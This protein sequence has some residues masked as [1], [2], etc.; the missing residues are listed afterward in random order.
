MQEIWGLIGMSLA[1]FVSFLGM[2]LAYVSYRKHKKGKK[3][4]SSKIS[5]EK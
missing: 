2:I 4:N 5:E 1:Y 3:Q